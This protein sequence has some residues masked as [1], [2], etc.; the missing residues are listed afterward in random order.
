MG[1]QKCTLRTLNCEADPEFSPD[2]ADPSLTRHVFKKRPIKD[3]Q[4]IHQSKKRTKAQKLSVERYFFINIKNIP[5][6]E[7]FYNGHPKMDTKMTHTARRPTM[8]LESI[9]RGEDWNYKT[10]TR[11]AWKMTPIPGSISPLFQDHLLPQGDSCQA[12]SS[13]LLEGDASPVRSLPPQRSWNLLSS[14]SQ[15]RPCSPRCFVRS[16]II[17]ALEICHQTNAV[18]P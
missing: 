7:V 5:L 6:R 2:R 13:L 9:K 10:N 17:H 1:E 18:Y 16:S 3:T 11:E 4:N 8:W 15:M 12:G 14:R